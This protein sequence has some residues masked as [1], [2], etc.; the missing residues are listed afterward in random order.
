MLAFPT[1]ELANASRRPVDDRHKKVALGRPPPLHPCPADTWAGR[2]AIRLLA[3]AFL[4]VL[5]SGCAGYQLGPTMGRQAGAASIQV[6]PFANETIEPRLSDAVTR[7]LRE[8]LQQDGTY[9]LDTH[10]E[11]DLIVS[12]NIVKYERMGVTFDPEDIITPR[13]FQ[14]TM[15]AHITVQERSSGRVVLA[16]DVMGRSTARLLADLPATERQAI[17]L[18][19]NDLARRAVSLLV[20]GEW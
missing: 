15:I 19:A 8:R 12:G 4:A 16:R 5:S 13:D 6:N 2:R 11:A 10:N 17:P 7:A 18:V 14:L 1:S 3:C 9:R 20:D